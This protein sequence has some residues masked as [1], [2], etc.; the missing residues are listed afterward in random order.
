MEKDYRKRLE[1]VLDRYSIITSD[2][3]K[4][5]DELEEIVGDARYDGW[6]DGHDPKTFWMD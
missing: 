6:E 2:R 4:I 3:E 1:Q 5:L